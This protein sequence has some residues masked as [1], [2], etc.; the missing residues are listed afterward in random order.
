VSGSLAFNAN[1]GAICLGQTFT[2]TPT[3]AATYTYSSGSA[4]VTPTTNTTYT[5]TG[6]SAAGCLGVQICSVTVNPI[7]TITLN[8]GV[9]CSGE[10]F[11]ITPSGTALTFTYS[12]GSDMVSPTSST[13]YTVSG[14][15]AEGCTSS[16]I[17]SVTV[18]PTPVVTVNT[19]S[20]CSG[21]SFTLVPAGASSYTY[22]GGS[23]VIT[24]TVNTT[25]T[26][27]GANSF[28]CQSN[29]VTTI[30][31]STTPV[32]SVNSGG[33]C[34]GGSYTIVPTGAVSYT[35]SG[36][37]DVVTPTTTTTYTVYG[38][39][40]DGCQSDAVVTVSVS[41]TLL[42]NTNSGGVCIGNSFTMTPTGAVSYTYSS[43]SN[44]VTPTVTTTY[45]ITAE[46]AAGCLGTD[47]CVV[48]VNAYPT[49]NAATS[50]TLICDGETATLTASGAT[51]Y[52]WSSGATTA[53]TAVTPT[54]TTTY[55]VTG[56]S[57]GCEATSSVTV[58]VSPC[59]GIRELSANTLNVS[60]APNPTHDVFTITVEKTTQVVITN[61][62]G[63]VVYNQTIEAGKQTI[64]MSHEANGLY[65]VKVTQGNLYQTIKVIK[66]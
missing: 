58:D 29:A 4:V 31:V 49:V 65:V 40:A 55:T 66:D 6:A 45:T 28:G 35:Y 36:G 21:Q 15:N 60:L 51:S 18:N 38:A 11:T 16:A 17:T 19:G 61:A 42:F 43:G 52:T 44:V 7:P 13:S 64:N 14:T 47:V 56:E 32:I 41:P 48:T 9:I 57:N 54:L 23:D 62:I 46:N 8:S 34:T 24:P 22:S 12:G 39:N 50:A 20:L 37:S 63:Q 25:Y 10:T 27:T 33:V 30:T 26:V 59:T 5:I 53:T 2:M 1:S 3:G